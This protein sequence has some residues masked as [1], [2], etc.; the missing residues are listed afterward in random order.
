MT[1]LDSLKQ[2]DSARVVDVAGDDGI[3]MRLMEMGVTEGEL[4]TVLGFAPLG[5]PMEL[6]IRGYHLSLRA[7]E[8]RR[9][10]IDPV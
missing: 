10:Q 7:S 1:T 5:D 2:G 9:V 6:R 8:A 3:A 4:V